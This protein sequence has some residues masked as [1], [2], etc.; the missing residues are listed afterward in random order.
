MKSQFKSLKNSKGF[1]LIEVI[2]VITVA[3][4][5]FTMMFAYFGTPVLDSAQPVIRLNQTLALTQTAERITAHFRQDHTAD[6]NVLKT[7]LTNNPSQYG[8]NFSIVTN[9]FVK[10]SKNND[11]KVKKKKD[12]KN[13]LKVKIRQDQTNETITLLFTQQT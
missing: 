1:T 2:V 8:Q 6:L 4:V 3:S 9:E 12:P 13:I 11:T 5:I 7:N 10:F